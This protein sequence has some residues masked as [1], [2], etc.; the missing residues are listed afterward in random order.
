MLLQFLQLPSMTYLGPE[1][2]SLAGEALPAKQKNAHE[3][4]SSSQQGREK[5]PQQFAACVPFL[6]CGNEL[7]SVKKPVISTVKSYWFSGSAFPFSSPLNRKS[8]ERQ[9]FSKPFR[10]PLNF[11]TSL[12]RV[13][14]PRGQVQCD[15][16][17]LTVLV[18]M[19]QLSFFTGLLFAIDKGHM[20]CSCNCTKFTDWA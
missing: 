11:S 19:P 6:L 10:F 2:T 20:H 5:Q 12:F 7:L 17:S 4:G 14:T 8:V 13:R 16:P 9:L 18:S 15:C 1:G 3:Q